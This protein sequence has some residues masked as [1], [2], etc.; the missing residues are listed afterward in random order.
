MRLHLHCLY[1]D[2]TKMYL[3]AV[4]KYPRLDNHESSRLPFNGN[5]TKAVVN[6]E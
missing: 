4:Q 2:K 5:K 3:S 6:T 1:L